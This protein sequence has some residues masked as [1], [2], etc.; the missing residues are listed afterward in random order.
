M[1]E[2]RVGP[3]HPRTRGEHCAALG[4]DDLGAGSP[5][6]TRGAHEQIARYYRERRITPA[7][8]GSTPQMALMAARARITPAYAGSTRRP[9]HRTSGQADHPRIR[10]E[11]T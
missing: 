4:S 6:H 9:F 11:H 10:G 2:K 3:D 1:C 5:P 7:H 8:A